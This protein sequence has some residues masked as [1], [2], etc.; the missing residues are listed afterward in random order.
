MMTFLWIVA[1][2]PLLFAVI[3]EIRGH[4][5]SLKFR[6]RKKP[7]LRPSLPCYFHGQNDPI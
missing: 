4:R 5:K 1:A 6:T 2:Q 7:A 3:L